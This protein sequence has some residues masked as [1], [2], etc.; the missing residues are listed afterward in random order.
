MSDLIKAEIYRIM[1]SSG[2][3]LIG[4]CLMGII[5]SFLN[6]SSEI[7]RQS[8]ITAA[9]MGMVFAQMALAVIIGGHY[10]NRTAYYEIMNGVS[11]SKRILSRICVYIPLMTALYFVPIGVILMACDGGAELGKFLLMFLLIFLRL[12]IFTICIC[13]IFKTVE[14]AILPYVRF[15]IESLIL[16][17]LTNEELGLS[18]DKIFS[19][20][21][22][23][24]S[25]QC[26]SL[27]GNIDNTLMMK[28]T[29]GLIAEC[30][31]MYALAYISNRQKWLIKS[32]F[33]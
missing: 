2:F 28:I 22:W 6:C 32:F 16:M 15:I 33:A 31:V 10:K 23:F 14:G 9:P 29:V 8:V 5:T 30:A 4:L 18:F 25:F 13:I 20:M 17:L 1:H 27:S 7:T 21:D 19:I 24:P 11:S 12:I 3:Y 26:N